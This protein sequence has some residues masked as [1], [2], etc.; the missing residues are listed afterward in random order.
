M[1]RKVFYACAV[2]AT[3]GLG[4]TGVASAF[5][6]QVFGGQYADYDCARQ[7][8]QDLVATPG[9]M[10]GTCDPDG[11]GNTVEHYGQWK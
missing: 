10:S 6:G 8:E 9:L 7:L 2:A 4:A 5:D 1:F 11:Y 3:I